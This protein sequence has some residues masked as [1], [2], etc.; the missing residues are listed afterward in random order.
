MTSA[1]AARAKS[2]SLTTKKRKAAAAA[3]V[4]NPAVATSRPKSKSQA[5]IDRRRERNR[6]LARRTRL[7]KKFFFE[8]LQKDVTDLQQQ[9]EKLRAVIRNRLPAELSNQILSSSRAKLPEIVAENPDFSVDVTQEDRNFVQT[10]RTSQQ[11][12]CI[13][14][15]S[16]I[17]NPIVYASAGF[18]DLTGYK[19]EEILGRNCRFLQGPGT[20]LKKVDELRSAI[21]R[22][23]DIQTTILNYKADGTSFY[24]HLFVAALKDASGAIVNYVGV[25]TE[26]AMPPPEDEEHEK[27]KQAAAGSQKQS[28]DDEAQAGNLDTS[29][30][31]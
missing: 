19:L 7:R 10:L 27:A 18:C 1:P 30:L 25:Q 15:P 28:P 20:S 23:E 17:D 5:Q 26:V 16:L 21:S 12:F 11:C 13:S 29:F 6:I 22:G 8:S 14:D 9:N 31:N 3:A 24:N 4:A 2:R